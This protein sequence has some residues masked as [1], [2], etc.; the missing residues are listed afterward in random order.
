[1]AS[2]EGKTFVAGD[3]Y[4]AADFTLGAKTVNLG[5]AVA[6][7]VAVGSRL[8]AMATDAVGN[9]S[10][11]SLT[12][13]VTGPAQTFLVNTTNDLDDGACDV[14]H[15]SLREAIDAATTNV[16]AVDSIHFGIPG[17]PPYVIQPQSPAAGRRRR[18]DPQRDH[19]AGVRRQPDRRALRRSRPAA[20]GLRLAAAGSTVRGLVVR[21]W[22]GIG[23]YDFAGNATIAGNFLGTDVT[24][25]L[26]QANG[27]GVFTNGSGTLVG[28]TTAADRNLISGNGTGLVLNSGSFAQGNW[29]GLDATGSARAAQRQRRQRAGRHSRRHRRGRSAISSPATRGVGVTVFG[30]A[31]LVQGNRIG[32]N[33]AGSATIGNGRRT[34]STPL[35]REAPSA[36]RLP[37]PATWSP[38]TAATASW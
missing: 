32:T 9:S 29:I 38:G 5:N 22:S 31:S 3:S 35:P 10:E 17:A 15:C 36:G 8:V 16:P 20:T 28:G 21:N 7:G 6:L 4:S 11:F 14:T 19:S 24:G 30:S 18:D 23:I 1:M 34:E 37:A 13:G 27:T 33:P 2:F 25:M 26:A 12:F